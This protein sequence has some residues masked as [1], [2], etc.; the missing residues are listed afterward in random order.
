MSKVDYLL[1]GKRNQNP[2]EK[3]DHESLGIQNVNER[4]KLIYG[5]EYGLSI[6]PV[7]EGET[8]STIIIPFVPN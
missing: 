2:S 8:A 6:E 1:S 5:E 7:G 3:P 4:I